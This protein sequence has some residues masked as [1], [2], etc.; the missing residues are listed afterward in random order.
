MP[1]DHQYLLF[2]L[3]VHVCVVCMGAYMYTCMYAHV[4]MCAEAYACMH[5]HVCMRTSPCLWIAGMLYFHE[6]GGLRLMCGTTSIVLPSYLMRQSSHQTQSSQT[7]LGKLPA[8]LDPLPPS[9][10][11]GIAWHFCGLWGSELQ[12]LQSKHFNHKRISP[13]LSISPPLL[14]FFFFF[15]CG[16]GGMKKEV[17]RKG[18]F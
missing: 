10:K 2:F 8:Y 1:K 18:V 11:G 14:D 16:A 7:W 3:C 4:C 15:F 6:N 12:S 17:E 9:Y 13:L 5:A